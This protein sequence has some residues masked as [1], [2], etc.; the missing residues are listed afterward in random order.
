MTAEFSTNWNDAFVSERAANEDAVTRPFHVSRILCP[1]DFSPT[2]E[3]AIAHASRL[4]ELYDASIDLLHVW[5]APAKGSAH[6]A[7][8]HYSD[9]L[10]AALDAA[11]ARVS[12]PRAFL[13]THL[14]NGE[15]WKE[16]AEIARQTRADLIV[17]GA[18][19]GS[20]AS[21]LGIGSVAERVLRLAPVPVLLVTPGS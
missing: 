19:G 16:I 17:M 1:T 8:G 21:A 10:H 9:R 11:L 13:R 14:V 15:P 6:D 12:R 7:V 5:A 3:R 2:S 4:A 20:G 18:T